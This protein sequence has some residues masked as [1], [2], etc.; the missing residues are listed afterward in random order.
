MSSFHHLTPE[1]RNIIVDGLNKGFSSR[2]I[3][4]LMNISVSTVQYWRQKFQQRGKLVFV[5]LISYPG[6]NKSSQSKLDEAR[7]LAKA[8]ECPFFTAKDLKD[9]LLLNFSERYIRK[10]LC[11]NGLKGRRAAKKENLN[12]IQQYARFLFAESLLSYDESYWRYVCFSDEKTFFVGHHGTIFVRRPNNMRF[13]PKYVAKKHCSGK[14][15]INVWGLISFNRG[16]LLKVIPSHMNSENY[17]DLLKNDALPKLLET[18]GDNFI[19]QQDNC[20]IHTA[21]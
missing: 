21:K 12:E 2:F 20:P 9:Y 14:F 5:A 7:L 17:L 10:L 19:F 11:K 3:S 1:Q 15:S 6:K 18:F 4:E 13:E 16:L 8:R